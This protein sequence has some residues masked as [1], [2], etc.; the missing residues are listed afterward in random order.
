MRYLVGFMFVLS[1]VALPL[2]VSA[3]EGEPSP[4]EPARGVQR[5]HPDAFVD[6]AD[7]TRSDF[8]IEYA[9][10]SAYSDMERRVD[11]A[12]TGLGI[13]VIPLVL[14]AVLATAGAMSS[15]NSGRPP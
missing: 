10:R 9:P 2:R 7:K 4:Q 3:Q 13:S 15:L 14:G 5:W 11:R 6:P 12:R 1:L 8:E